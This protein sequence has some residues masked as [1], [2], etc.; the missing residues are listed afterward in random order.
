MQIFPGSHLTSRRYLTPFLCFVS[1]LLI[2]LLLSACG[3]KAQPTNWVG[4]ATWQ[5]IYSQTAIPIEVTQAPNTD[6][7]TPLPE[8][9]PTPNEQT[10]SSLG[11]NRTELKGLTVNLWY[12]WTGS[13]GAAMQALLNEFNRTNKWGITI[14]GQSYE[15]FGRLD[16]ATEQAINAGSLP[17]ILID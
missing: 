14:E 8:V 9:P 16:D 5:S 15:G 3:K 6:T 13:A 2:V 4:T 12:P 17:D 1:G 7:P 10:P 11:V